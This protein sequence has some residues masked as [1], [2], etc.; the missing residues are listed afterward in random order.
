MSSLSKFS[1]KESARTHEEARAV[2]CCVCGRKVKD[3]RT[4]TD[5]LAGLVNEHVYTGYATEKDAF[6]VGICS[7]CQHTLDS[8]E[9]ALCN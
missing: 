2:V 4:V 9:K 6:P 5:G 7:T 3:G 8:L 1:K